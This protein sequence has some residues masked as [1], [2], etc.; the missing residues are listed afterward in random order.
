MSELSA[1]EALDLLPND[2]GFVLRRTDH[3]GHITQ[4][5]LSESNVLI[6]PRLAHERA[7]RILETRTTPALKAQGA[8]AGIW[9]PVAQARVGQNIHQSSV[10]L[11]IED[12]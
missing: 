11:E 8:S 2:N 1:T 3:L 9:A 6:L 12:A 5:D 4:L 10:F 7:V